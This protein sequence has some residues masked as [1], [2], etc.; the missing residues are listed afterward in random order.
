MGSCQTLTKSIYPN[1]CSPSPSLQALKR[2]EWPKEAR[3]GLK[4]VLGAGLTT[5]PTDCLQVCCPSRRP[6]SSPLTSEPSG[7][8][9][10]CV[11]VQMGGSD[12]LFSSPIS[13]QTTQW[14]SCQTSRRAYGP[15]PPWRPP[16][17]RPSPRWRHFRYYYCCTEH[18]KGLLLADIFFRDYNEDSL[19]GQTTDSKRQVSCAQCWPQAR[20]LELA[21]HKR[22][23]LHPACRATRSA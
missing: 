23:R 16:L 5:H 13:Q 8:I 20:I 4:L 11:W 1:L 9:S 3:V 12:L 10:N 18:M 21:K 17:S 6:L 19:W 15:I 7:R 14:W 2:Q 22:T